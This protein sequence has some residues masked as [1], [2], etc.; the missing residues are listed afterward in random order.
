MTVTEAEAA[1]QRV[2][3]WLSSIDIRWLWGEGGPIALLTRQDALEL[4]E[5]LL[6]ES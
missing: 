2:S 3:A 5:G 6:D 4:M 1:I